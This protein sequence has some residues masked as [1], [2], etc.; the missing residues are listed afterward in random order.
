MNFPIL[1]T[2][3]EII[4]LMRKTMT[5]ASENLLCFF[6]SHLKAYIT[7]PVFM[8]VPM[9]DK[10][11]HR[12]YAVFETTKIFKNKIYQLDKHIQRFENSIKLINLKSKYSTKEYK[13]I[14]QTL[15]AI[16]RKERT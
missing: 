3:S 12:G 13:E 11:I 9:E 8:N 14:L 6:S 15:G 16:A 1:K 7:D 5:P 4:N 10:M 2:E